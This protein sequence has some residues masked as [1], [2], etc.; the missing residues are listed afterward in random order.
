M[1]ISVVRRTLSSAAV[2]ALLLPGAVLAQ[3]YHRTDLT[4]DSS[5]AS[6]TA[7]NPDTNLVDAWGLARGSGGPWWV[8]DNG[9]GVSTLYNAAGVPSTRRHKTTSGEDSPSRRHWS[10]GSLPEPWSLQPPDFWWGQV[11][12]HF[13]CS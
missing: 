12:R 4:A 8:S 3:Q 5:A 9:T 2:V 11:L 1:W 10:L 6:S 7:P 13:S